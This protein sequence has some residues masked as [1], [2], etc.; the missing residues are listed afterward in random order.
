MNLSSPLK[1]TH[2]LHVI[3]V[4]VLAMLV[5]VW[6]LSMQ[7]AVALE[8]E[9]E[10]KIAEVHQRH[11]ADLAQLREVHQQSVLN[12]ARAAKEDREVLS[13]V[14]HEAREAEARARV[15]GKVQLD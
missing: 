2:C 9:L 11:K 13:R 6:Y 15:P 7:R 14:K 1:R 4:S 12:R 3:S 5:F 10:T 8:R